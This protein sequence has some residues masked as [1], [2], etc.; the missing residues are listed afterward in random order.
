MTSTWWPVPARPSTWFTEE[1]LAASAVYHEPLAR[2]AGM[3]GTARLVGLVLAGLLCR[4]LSPDRSWLAQLAASSILVSVVWWLPAVAS[5]WWFDQR[6]DP[7]FG[8]VALPA[9]Q[10]LVGSSLAL[11]GTL[12][13][14][15]LSGGSVFALRGSVRYWWLVVVLA[16]VIIGLLLSILQHRT[17]MHTRSLDPLPIVEDKVYRY[18]AEAAGVEGVSFWGMKSTLETGL[19]ALTLADIWGSGVRIALTDQLSA[20]PEDLRKTVIAHELAHVRAGHLRQMLLVGLASAAAVAAVVTLVLASPALWLLLAGVEP[21]DPRGLPALAL[22]V[23]LSG[24]VVGLGPDWLARAQERQADLAASELV[25]PIAEPLLRLLH[26]TDRA[27]LDPGRMSRLLSAHPPPAER[28]HRAALIH[29][30]ILQESWPTS[31]GAEP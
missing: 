29:G 8:G 7:R 25:G 24:L 19:N 9:G 31:P 28:L 23:W 18:L 14:V 21:S 16:V 4:E 11:T 22:T 3:R 1:Q 30:A 13:G 15:G 17:S 5:D 10:L 26:V 6:H 2:V 27:D 12:M 20:A